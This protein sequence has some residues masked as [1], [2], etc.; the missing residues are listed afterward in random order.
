[1][2]IRN[3]LVSSLVVV[4]TGCATFE[5]QRASLD[6]KYNREVEAIKTFFAQCEDD[7]CRENL[8]NIYDEIRAKYNRDTQS[9]LIAEIN[10][11]NM[12]GAVLANQALTP[13]YRP[14]YQQNYQQNYQQQRQLNQITQQLN[15]QNWQLQQSG[16][17]NQHGLSVP[18]QY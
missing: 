4:L 6:E 18:Y 13:I 1:M 9:L 14:T 2:K 8:V 17:Y 15:N 3:L 7:K 5:S 10:R 16:Y 11:V 12:A